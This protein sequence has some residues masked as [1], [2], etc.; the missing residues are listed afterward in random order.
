MKT[1]MIYQT[2]E[3]ITPNKLYVIGQRFC[4]GRFTGYIY[5]YGKLDK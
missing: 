2:P 1:E 4:D 3:C 5:H